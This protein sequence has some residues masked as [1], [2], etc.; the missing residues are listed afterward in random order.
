MILLLSGCRL[1]FFFGI[2]QNITQDVKKNW[3]NLFF[4]L[5]VIPPADM[6]WTLR[7]PQMTGEIFTINNEEHFVIAIDTSPAQSGDVPDPPSPQKKQRK[8]TLIT[9][10]TDDDTQP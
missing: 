3:Y 9:G 5:L 8:L 6:A 2:V 4:K 1:E 10:D 7:R